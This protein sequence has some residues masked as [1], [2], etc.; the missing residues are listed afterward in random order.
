[1]DW[2]RIT[3]RELS[4]A[5]EVTDGVCIIPFGCLERHSDFLPLGT[6]S[7]LAHRLACLAAEQ[8]PAVVFPPQHYMMVASA[9][10]F[11]GA[12]S[13]DVSLSIKIIEALFDEL[14]RNGF[15]KLILYNFHGGNRNILP[16]LVQNHLPRRRRHYALY[17]PKFDW[18][19]E[20]VHK[21][22]CESNFGGHADEW[23]TSLMMYLFPD[24]VKSDQ[25]PARE[26]GQPQNRLKHL[27]DIKTS[28]SFYADYPTHYAGEA[29]HA[30]SERGKRAVDSIVRR[31]S[32]VIRAVKNDDKVL[33]L[34]CEF[35]DRMDGRSGT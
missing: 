16:L 34:L 26:T 33:P 28:V 30:T 6:D 14:A 9:A 20:D 25:I 19:V 10:A 31:L 1:M 7:L 27:E 5:M 17:L 2:T 13:F 11:P 12:I 29:E 35:H 8:E 18:E 15:R 23:E 24:C 3:S 22:Y 21:E 32:K 4:Q